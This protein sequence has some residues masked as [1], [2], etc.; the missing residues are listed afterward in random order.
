MHDHMVSELT[1]HRCM[2]SI[3]VGGRYRL[4]D[5]VLSAY[6]NAGIEEVGVITKSNYQS[7]MDHLGTGREWDLSRKR[8]GLVILPPFGSASTGSMYRNRIEALMGIMS[9]MRNN[10]AEYILGTDC[11]YIGNLDL[12]DFMDSHEKSG[13]DISL[14]YKEMPVEAESGK[15][16]TTFT[17]DKD[18]NVIDMLIH[19]EITGKQNVYI[20]V[21]L[22]SKKLLERAVVDCYSRNQLSFNRDILQAG[23]GK[24]KIHAY[25][26]T[27]YASRFD[28]LKGY[29]KTN[30]AL[31]DSDVRKDLFPQDRPIYT[32]I[33]DEAP[34]RYGLDSKVKNSLLGDGCIVE[35]EV[36][37][38][39]LFRGVT[40]GKG[41]KVKGCIV[42]QGTNVGENSNLEYVITDKDVKIN[43]D[44]NIKGFSTYPVFISKG[45]EV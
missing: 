45:S 25:E 23:I 34:V 29:Y 36:E 7:L 16:I 15:D 22:M 40:I 13:A 5:F 12:A 33:R 43:N 39:I 21:F 3:P 9:Y 20:N 28:S 31:L 4:I 2:G 41:A 27:G 17:L 18:K 35:G 38:S 30:M 32:K 6:A 11:D 42:M 14:I 8:G 24:Y 1:E 37:D 26:Y 10:K 44:R 19:P